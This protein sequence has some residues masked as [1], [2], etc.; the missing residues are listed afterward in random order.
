MS[1]YP[2]Y[3][4]GGVMVETRDGGQWVHRE[5]INR[6]AEG[7]ALTE[8]QVLEKFMG[9]A[10]RTISEA[11]ARRVWEAVMHLESAPDLSELLDAIAR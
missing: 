9:N 4:S 1:R 6:G 8:S 11:Q 5:P 2:E 3:Y 7:R 10:T